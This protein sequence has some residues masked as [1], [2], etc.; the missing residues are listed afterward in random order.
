MIRKEWEHEKPGLAIES[1]SVLVALLS[2]DEILYVT[3][4]SFYFSSYSFRFSISFSFVIFLSFFLSV[5][6][7]FCWSVSGFGKCARPAAAGGALNLG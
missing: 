4:Y 2:H 1:S 6:L 3:H 5:F 7:F